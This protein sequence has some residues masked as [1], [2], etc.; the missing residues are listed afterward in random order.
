MG[1]F[2]ETSFT[3]ADRWTNYHASKLNLTISPQDDMLEPGQ[4]QHYLAVGTC[5]LEALSEAMLLAR[6]SSFSS[7]LDVPCGYG[8]ITR[9]LVNFFSDA[10]VFVSEIDKAKQD[11]C[12]R[13]FGA[14]PID[15]PPDFVGA[16]PRH[17]DLIVVASLVTHFNAA[18][19]INALRYLLKC[20]SEGGL[21]V[22]STHGRY[23]TVSADERG[24]LL[25]R[26]W[27]AFMRRGFGYE[28]SPTY[29]DSRMAPSWVLRTLECVPDARVIGH[30]ERGWDGFQ[31]MFVI[32]RATAWTRAR[33][34]RSRWLHLRAILPDLGD[35]HWARLAWRRARRALRRLREPPTR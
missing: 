9:H 20:L 10:E 3:I 7:V 14:K 32:E 8:R 21:L 29:G 4:L 35:D 27:R 23:A 22:F 24:H 11:F 33:P 1:G 13:T 19:S 15:L 16:P 17:F 26:T 12:S 25:R 28:G 2:V 34:A 30:K 18:R 31:D 6:R 5:A